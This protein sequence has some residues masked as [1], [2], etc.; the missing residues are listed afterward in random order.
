MTLTPKDFLTLRTGRIYFDMPSVK[1]Y[2]DVVVSEFK[3]YFYWD[4]E[5]AFQQKELVEESIKTLTTFE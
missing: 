3:N 5:E 2:K 4:E 1:K